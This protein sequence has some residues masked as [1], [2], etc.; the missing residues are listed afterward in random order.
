AGCT[1]I[2]G[3]TK[4][5]KFVQIGGA[6]CINGHIQIGDGAKVAGMSGIMR[7]VAPMQ[8]VAG[9]PA[10]PIRDWHKLNS[11]LIALIKKSE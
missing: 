3:S 7:D 6:C 1:A 2:A 10:M 4:V 11:K 5:G 8:V 9:A